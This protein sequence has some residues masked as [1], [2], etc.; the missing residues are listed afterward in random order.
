VRAVRLRVAAV[1]RRTDRG[2]HLPSG[3]IMWD[4]FYECPA[5]GV[6]HMKAWSSFYRDFKVPPMHCSD[7]RE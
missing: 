3:R 6:L 7:C 5:C 4:I 1:W 2:D